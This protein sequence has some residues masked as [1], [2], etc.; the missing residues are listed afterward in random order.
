MSIFQLN[1]L[2][3]FSKQFCRHVVDF[4]YA[5]LLGYLTHHGQVFLEQTVPIIFGTHRKPEIQRTN[6]I[7]I[8]KISNLNIITPPEMFGDTAG[9]GPFHAQL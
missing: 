8:I 1:F 2:K 3:F 9:K 5:D 6:E 4:L 7:L